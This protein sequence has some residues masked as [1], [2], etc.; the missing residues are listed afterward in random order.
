M[1]ITGHKTLA[2]L[3]RYNTIDVEDRHDAMKK[4]AKTRR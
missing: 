2:M 3:E 4:M 1:Q